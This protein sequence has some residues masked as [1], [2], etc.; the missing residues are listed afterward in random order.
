MNSV[1]SPRYSN[2]AEERQFNKHSNKNR[3]R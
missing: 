2:I 3:Q 1:T